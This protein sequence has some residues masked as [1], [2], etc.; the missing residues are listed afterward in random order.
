MLA[1][2]LEAATPTLHHTLDA[3]SSSTSSTRRDFLCGAG[4]A[5]SGAALAPAVAD[6]AEPAALAPGKVWRIGVISTS[7][8]GRPQKTNGHTYHFAQGFHPT[9]DLKA[10]EKHLSKGPVDLFKS[11]FRNPKED[12]AQLPFSDTRISGYYDA[13]AA[14]AAMF[15]ECFPGVPVAR[16]LDELVR[17]SDAIW[18]GDASGRGEDHFE[19]CAP[20][21]EKGLPTFCDKPIGGTVAETRKI[22]EFARKHKAPLMSSSLFR[23]Q[24]GTEEA[25]RMKRSGEFGPLQ[26]VIASQAGGWSYQ[27]WFIY[28]Q[29]PTWMAMTLCGAG[30]EAVS[31]YAREATCHALLTWPDRMPAEVWYGRPDVAPTYSHTSAHFAKKTHEW[32]PAIDGNYWFGHHYQIFRMAQVFLHMVKTRVEPVP[33]QEILEVTAILHAGAKS[34]NERGRLVALAEVM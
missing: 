28:G 18:V 10:I 34:L 11:H 5:V 4:A 8:G 6:A 20:G 12:F 16:T 17:N 2:G 23:H 1:P 14:S 33:H 13:D 30:V 26:Y 31:M 25:L 15:A 27:G 3:M 22:L 29:H 32:T 7:I 19:L 21:L 9:V 24:W